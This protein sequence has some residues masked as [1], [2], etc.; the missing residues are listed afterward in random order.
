ML[1]R[2]GHTILLVFAILYFLI[3][4]LFFSLLRPLRRWLMSLHA[5][6]RLSVW[7][8]ALNRYVALLLLLVPWLLLEPLKPI[9]FVLFAHHHHIT[10]IL[11]II[12]SELVKLTLF[13]QMFDMAKP[14]LMSFRWFAWGYDHWQETR[15]YLRSLPAI[16]RI[17]DWYR[18]MRTWVLGFAAEVRRR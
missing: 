18:G 1:R 10:S 2:T 3:D 4:V 12:G 5:R 13:E 16:S 11:L 6:Q 7:I 9:G 8:G 17:R 14:K 15:H